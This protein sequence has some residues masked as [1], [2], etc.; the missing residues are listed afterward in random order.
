M[1]NLGNEQVAEVSQEQVFDNQVEKSDSPIQADMSDEEN[2]L[3]AYRLSSPSILA[4]TI[5]KCDRKEFS[6]FL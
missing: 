4:C 1:E 2:K 6:I 3:L 5:C